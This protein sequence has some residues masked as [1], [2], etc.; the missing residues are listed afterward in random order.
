MKKKL[1]TIYAVIGA[2]AAITGVVASIINFRK[3]VIRIS[4]CD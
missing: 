3:R 1:I 2:I 4:E